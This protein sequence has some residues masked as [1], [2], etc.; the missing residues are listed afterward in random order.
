MRYTEDTIRRW[1]YNRMRENQYFFKKLSK[2][3]QTGI[4]YADASAIQEG[5]IESFCESPE[6][7]PIATCK[8]LQKRLMD[9]ANGQEKPYIFKDEFWV[10]FACIKCAGGFV[11][12]GPM[13]LEL[14]NHVELFQYGKKYQIKAEQTKR[15]KHFP[16]SRM[17][18]LIEMAAEQ[19]QGKIY[20]DEELILANHI[21]KDTKI[22]EKKEQILFELKASEEEMYHHTYQ[23][24][25][26][27]LD[28][29]RDG[30]SEDA[31]RYSRNMD[32]E[33]G[34]LSA[35]EMNHWK[36]VAI[37]AITLTTRAAIEGGIS[38]SVAYRISDF[39]IQKSDSCKD[40]A[41]IIK[42]RDH[43]VEE[44]TGQVEKKKSRRTSSYVERCRD[45]VG[46]HY[47]EK[48]YLSEIADTLGL[49]ETYLSRLFRKETGERLQD[50]I[51]GVRL[52]H[53]ANLLKYSE[54][55]ISKIAEYVNFPSQ[56]YMGKV[57]KEKYEMSPKQYREQ[58]RPTEY[59]QEK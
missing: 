13:S 28:S 10:C 32:S 27:L 58:K 8:E 25:R 59:F 47:R 39:Y 46:K 3:M 20:E 48:I 18:D 51:V 9:G 36:N 49:S 15:L 44:L 34:K 24:E 6:Y 37:V 55:S 2:L 11:M 7:N 14:L 5:Q 40:I 54:E 26:K 45:Y 4:F 41:Q 43:A 16:F 1:I 19:I 42:Y 38:P 33:L 23:E 30:R 29:V 31:I 52:E 17:L 56:S 53:A 50:Y 12:I 21:A 22:Q 57:F 35:K